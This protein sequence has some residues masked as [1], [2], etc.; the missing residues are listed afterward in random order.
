VEDESKMEK[1]LDILTPLMITE[2]IEE[3]YI[4]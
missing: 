4:I 2:D 3:D 1:W